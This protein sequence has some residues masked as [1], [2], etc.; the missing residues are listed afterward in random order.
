MAK[1]KK[2]F[3]PDSPGAGFFSRI[4]ITPS[5]RLVLLRWTLYGL[6]ALTALLLQDVIFSRFAKTD[7]VPMVLLLIG[8]MA[9]A[10]SGGM[11]VM[12]ASCIYVLSGSSPGV[13]VILVLTVFTVVGSI[14][15]AA[16]LRKGFSSSMIITGTLLLCYE[17]AMWLFGIFMRLTRPGRLWVFL[18]TWLVTCLAMPVVYLVVQAIDRIGGETWKE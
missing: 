18:L 14:F 15:R 9:G 10:E 16:F 8:L 17:L 5:Q 11:F 6:C 12:I 2:D 13:Q 1:K 4:Y 7:L 3:L